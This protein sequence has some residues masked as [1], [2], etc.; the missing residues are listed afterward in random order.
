ME[1]TNTPEFLQCYGICRALFAIQSRYLPKD[2]ADPDIVEHNLFPAS[3]GIRELIRP[4]V[5]TIK[6][7]PGSPRRYTIAPFVK[8]LTCLLP[9]KA[10]RAI[11]GSRPRNVLCVKKGRMPSSGAM[12][13]LGTRS[14]HQLAAPP[15]PAGR[16]IWNDPAWA[17][18]FWEPAS[19]LCNA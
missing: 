15:Q 14:Q 6:L 11:L 12:T 19:P 18:S 8:L 7:S 1:T 16:C 13:I 9:I 2:V 17:N 3:A 10:S 5:T 4:L